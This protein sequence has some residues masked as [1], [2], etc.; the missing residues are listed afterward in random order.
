MTFKSLN[1]CVNFLE[2]QGELIRVKEEID[3]DLEMAEVTRRVFQNDGPALLF[4]NIKAT[5]FPAV[6]NLY[7]NYERALKIFEPGFDR[8]KQIIKIKSDLKSLIKPPLFKSLTASLKTLPAFI[9]VLPVRKRTGKVLARKTKIENLPMIRCWPK[10]GGGFILL[11]Q[12][13]SMNPERNSILDSNMGMYRIQISGGDYIKN[14][15]IGLHYQIHRGIG[16]HHLKAL[17][18]GVP[19]RVS[20]FIGGPP[21]HAFAAVMPM[22]EN[23]SELCFAGA[24]AGRNFRYCIKS[25]FVVSADADFCITGRIVPG[26]TKKEG[27]FGDHLGYYSLEHE[28]PYLEVE[29]VWHRK[30]AIFPFIVVGQPP[31]EDTIFGKLIHELTEPEIPKS[32]PGV[33]RIHA[34][35]AAGV[36][37]LLLAKAHERYVPY[38]IRKPREI[39]TYANAILGTG[40]LSLAKYLL[41]CAHEDN[42]DLDITN[43]KEFILHLLER[44]DFSRDLH[45]QTQTTMD[46]LDY[47]SENLNR[48]SKLIMA[49][50]GK[51]KRKLSKKIPIEFSSDKSFSNPQMAAPGIIVIKGPIFTNYDKALKEINCLLTSLD[52]KQIME[53]LPLLIIADN[54]EYICSKFSNFLWTVF[55]KSNP[56][57]DIYGAKSFTKF[58]HWGCSAPLV[59]DAREK[60][61]H[62]P[63]LVPDK[64]VAKNVERFGLK[65]K[66]L[67]GVF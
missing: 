8:I 67:A 33:T 16:N 7:G 28:F 57:H 42:P 32:I 23:M 50:A 39:L 5:P 37:P 47:S 6:S 53:G 38:E 11:P 46:T 18:L 56:S 65:G 15:E 43:E 26:K 3:P 25:G 19:L 41:I 1:D 34:V 2:N 12:V 36:H 60:S 52:N 14:R 27:P 9:H 45:F 59:I 31:Q 40:Q 24:L 49:A 55:T 29:S 63:L 51:K 20:I 30:D 64:K 54:V 35:D 62:A 58:K 44:I 4:E 10:E 66:S 22:P 61:F 48:G 13:F 17:Q 21:A